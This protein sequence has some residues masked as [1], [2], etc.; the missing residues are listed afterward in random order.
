[1]HADG[2]PVSYPTGRGRNDGRYLGAGYPVDGEAIAG[3]PST[4]GS[5]HHKGHSHPRELSSVGEAGFEPATARPPAGC[6]T[7]LRHSPWPASLRD[8]SSG[9]CENVCSN[10]GRRPEQNAALWSLRSIQDLL[11]ICMATGGA[12]STGQPLSAFA[13]PSTTGALPRES[14]SLRGAGSVAQASARPHAHQVP[15][16]VLRD[17]FVRRLWRVRSDSPRVRPLEQ[18]DV[19]DR[20]GSAVPERAEHPRRDRQVRRRLRE[21]PSASNRPNKRL[22][23]S[24]ANADEPRDRLE[25]VSGIEPELRPWKGLVQPLHHTREK[26][27][28]YSNWPKSRSATSKTANDPP[29]VESASFIRT[30]PAAASMIRQSGAGGASPAAPGVSGTV[31]A[32]PRPTGVQTSAT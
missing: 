32:A 24:S 13:D 27:R 9:S 8:V 25:R 23:A 26:S 29:G 20:P 28:R 31:R 2:Y 17:S 3:A 4:T 15:A 14:R 7:R 10:G 11:R 16:R 22:A 1:L 12:W 19:R 30:T 6:A 5:L 18:Q 21:R